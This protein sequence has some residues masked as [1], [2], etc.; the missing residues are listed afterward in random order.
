MVA[1]GRN[2]ICC[3]QQGGGTTAELVGE[4]DS[5]GGLTSTGSTTVG[6]WPAEALEAQGDGAQ[7]GTGTLA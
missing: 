1:G 5:S 2:R 4:D 6:Y 3:P 7:M